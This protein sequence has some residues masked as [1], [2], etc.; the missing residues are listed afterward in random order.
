MTEVLDSLL[1]SESRRGGSH[2]H[3]YR[4]TAHTQPRYSFKTAWLSTSLIITSVEIVKFKNNVWIQFYY[5]LF[6]VHEHKYR[7]RNQVRLKKRMMIPCC[8]SKCQFLHEQVNVLVHLEP[9][10]IVGVTLKSHEE[11][12]VRNVGGQSP[13]G[14]GWDLVTLNLE[15]VINS[16]I[17]LIF[18]L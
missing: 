2:H 5:L 13:R 6:I 1:D 17:T 7:K 15:N 11:T 3:R 10:Q 16:S 4:R 18:Q 8:S 9:V 12:T 14:V